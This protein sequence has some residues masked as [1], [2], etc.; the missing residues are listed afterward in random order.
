MSGQ[1]LNEQRKK[2]S[3][4]RMFSRILSQT[5]S[6][7]GVSQENIDLKRSN[8]ELRKR[9]S[10]LITELDIEKSKEKHVNEEEMPKDKGI[11][12]NS[13]ITKSKTNEMGKMETKANMGHG[14]E[15][16]CEEKEQ[17]IQ[18]DFVKKLSILTKKEDEMSCKDQSITIGKNER[19]SNF[20]IETHDI[21]CENPKCN[22]KCLPEIKQL[23][24]SLRDQKDENTRLHLSISRL[25]E[26]KKELNRRVTEY[27]YGLIFSEKKKKDV[28]FEK[29]PEANNTIK[30]LKVKPEHL[31][32]SGSS[33]GLLSSSV[34][35][36]N[37]SSKD[38]IS[39]DQKSED[40]KRKH[41]T[42]TRNMYDEPAKTIKASVNCIDNELKNNLSEDSPTTYF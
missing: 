35:D 33:I 28:D 3:G 18:R 2:S 1:L 29:L 41:Q 8:E 6:D 34:K 7:D 23:A 31:I 15:Y 10:R 38:D 9:I 21:K 16:K 5:F 19:I 24:K 30:E 17:S 12:E 39:I 20:D 22:S 40:A 36:I 11:Q 42:E 4:S 25:I 14:Y 26:E 27:T 13:Q 32:K 37:K